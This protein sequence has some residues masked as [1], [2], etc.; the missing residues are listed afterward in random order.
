MPESAWLQELEDRGLIADCTDLEALDERLSGAPARLYIGFDPSAP[1]LHAGSLIPLFLVRRFR[2]HGHSPVCLIGGATGMIG[3]PTGRSDE[4]NLLS[5]EVLDEYRESLGAQI[6]ALVGED[7]LVVD[8]RDWLGPIPVL[9]FLR[10]VGVHFPVSIM[11]NRESVRQRRESPTGITFTEFSYQLLQGYD[12]WWLRTHEDVELQIGGTDQWG[13]ITA[14][15]DYMRRRDGSVAWGLVFPLLLKADGSKFGKSSGGG[16]VWLDRE[17]TSPFEF[18]QFWFNTDDADVEEMLMRFCERPVDEIRAIGARH[19]ANPP[20][21]EAQRVLANDVTTWVHG[22]EL[23]RAAEQ[24][25]GVLFGRDARAGEA[26][27]EPALDL[28]EREVGALRLSRKELD[29][30]P[31]AELAVRGGL[32]PSLNEARRVASGGGLY[33]GDKAVEAAATFSLND[34]AE[35]GWALVRR[36]RRNWLLVRAT[37]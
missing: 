12:F 14:G 26:L 18:W 5:E 33:V 36:G 7:V 17:L 1:S 29:G 37:D 30:M 10:E 27:D 25:A 15:I 20:A 34:L 3:D 28:V 19:A 31:V 2:A 21:R 11:L 35:P 32:V 23:A 6:R 4:R 16:N 13:N 8:N 24:A 22:V 9:T